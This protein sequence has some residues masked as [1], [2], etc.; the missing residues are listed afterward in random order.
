[1]KLQDLDEID[2]QYKYFKCHDSYLE[3]K[4]RNHNICKVE[5]IRMRQYVSHFSSLVYIHARTYPNFSS[6]LLRLFPVICVFLGCWWFVTDNWALLLT[7]WYCD[8]LCLLVE[9]QQI[10]WRHNNVIMTSQ[11]LHNV[12]T[13]T[14]RFAGFL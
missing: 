5:K 9:Y 10:L 6:A 13:M 11:W 12:V 7:L 2:T 4:A 14:L 1:M 3:Y 8:L